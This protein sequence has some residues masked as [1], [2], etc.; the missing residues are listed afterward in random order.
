MWP[1]IG[2]LN[3]SQVCLPLFVKPRLTHIFK[4]CFREIQVLA[5]W[6]SSKLGVGKY[7]PWVYWLA[8]KQ[9]DQIASWDYHGT[10]HLWTHWTWTGQGITF[11]SVVCSYDVVSVWQQAGAALLPSHYPI[12]LLS[13]LLSVW[14]AWFLFPWQDPFML[15]ISLIFLP[16]REGIKA[17]LIP[18][19]AT[20]LYEGDVND[21]K[22]PLFDCYE[23]WMRWSCVSC[24][25]GDGSWIQGSQ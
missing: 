22:M 7:K 18:S 16:M 14:S 19:W 13:R 11:F 4:I 20:M 6:P 5:A 9:F 23:G 17:L 24:V 8:V 1:R 25:A 10:D 15:T 21:V 2:A 12:L 3:S